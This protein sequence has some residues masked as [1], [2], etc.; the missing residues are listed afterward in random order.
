MNVVIQ[1]SQK[2]VS[3]YLELELLMVEHSALVL[4]PNLGPLEEQYAILM[5]DGPSLQSLLLPCRLSDDS[6]RTEAPQRSTC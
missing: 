3:D 2:R 6:A 1:G 4:G 5:A